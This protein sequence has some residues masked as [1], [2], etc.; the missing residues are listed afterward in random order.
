MYKITI[1]TKYTELVFH[2]SGD[3]TLAE[4]HAVIFDKLKTLT[5]EE[6]KEYKVSSIK[7]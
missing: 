1:K 2:L 3:T 5:N 6:L 7:E 4:R